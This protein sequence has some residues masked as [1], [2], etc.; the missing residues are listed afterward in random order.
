MKTLIPPRRRWMV[1]LLLAAFV[2]LI[3]LGSRELWPPD[4]PRFGL[5][6][7][8]MLRDGSFVVPHLQGEIYTNKPPLYLWMAALLSM[9]TGGVSEWA[10]RVPSALAAIGSVLLVYGLGRRWWGERSGWISA[11]VL[12]TAGHFLLR[13][14][15]ASTDMSLGFFFLLS[16]VLLAACLGL[17]RGNHIHL[18]AGRWFFVAAAL[19]TLTKG[20]VGIVLPIGILVIFL[21]LERRAGDLLRF[22]WMSGV[23]LFVLIVAP[24][25]VLYGLEAGGGRLGVV[26]IKENVARYLNAWNNVQPFYY[27]LHRFPLSFLPWSLFFPAVIVALVRRWRAGA[28][29]PLRF[30]TVWFAVVFLFFSISSGKRTVYL[31]PLFPAAALLVGW[32][33]DRGWESLGRTAASWV[34][35]T[36]AGL[37]GLLLVGAAA[38]PVLASTRLNEALPAAIAIAIILATATVPLIA[39]GW[40]VRVPAVAGTVAATVLLTALVS[41]FWLV[42]PLD[43]YHNVRRL[44][45][46]ITRVVP[47]GSRLATARKKREAFFFYTGLNGEEIRNEADLARILGSAEPAFCLLPE[48]DWD[49]YSRRIETDAA[50]LLRGPASHHTYVLVSN[51]VTHDSQIR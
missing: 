33:L 3:R 11:L 6:A 20:P 47:P 14:R 8:E 10:A 37:A 23:A 19:A 26:L 32:F 13:G 9:A 38:L 36:V 42:P 4:E 41:V 51:E 22:P 50:V 44:S 21:V 2:F 16:M 24:W 49:R 1:L 12:M 27:Y 7:Q 30:L 18:G 31:L 17:G 5:I 35:A 15:W 40:K 39:A 25:Y 46:R 34:R 29:A 48:P 28:A 45:A 43:R